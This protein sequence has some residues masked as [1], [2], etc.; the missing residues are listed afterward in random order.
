M[1]TWGTAIFSDDFASD[2]KSEFR[3]KIAF[4]KEPEEATQELINEYKDVLDDPEEASVFWIALA[5]TQWNL[6]R[7]Q[8]DVKQKALQILDSGT[9]LNRW[10]DNPKEYKKRIEVLNKLKEQLLSKQPL[11]KKLPIPFIRETK[12]IEGNL[13]SYTH[14][15]GNIAILRVIGINRDH[16]GDTYP[17]VEILNHFNAS[18]PS[19]KEIEEID[20]LREKDTNDF[21][22]PSNAFLIAPYGKKDSEPW[23]K[24]KVL[25]EKV[26]IRENI[27]GS[28]PLIWWKNF[29]DFL[30]E[31]FK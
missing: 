15:N 18:I 26:K 23:N 31:R 19:I 9:D 4:G 2:L 12:L 30:L 8:E 25:K 21:P 10:K 17:R 29:D 7:L 16:C 28:T 24:I 5:A 14:S 11:A 22:K 3:D 1:G 13:I 27:S 6:G 20:I